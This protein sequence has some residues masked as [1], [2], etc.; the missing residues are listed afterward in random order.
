MRVGTGAAEAK[1][2]R[3]WVKRQIR[4]LTIDET[5]MG[6]KEVMPLSRET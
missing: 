1:P 3:L 6:R 5:C 4:V 2:V